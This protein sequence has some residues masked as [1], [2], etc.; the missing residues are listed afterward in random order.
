[1]T[2]GPKLESPFLRWLWT[3]RCPRCGLAL[4]R[5]PDPEIVWCLNHG[6]L[7]VGAVIEPTPRSAGPRT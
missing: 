4:R 3:P 7:Y 2:T 5:T 6:D 1:M